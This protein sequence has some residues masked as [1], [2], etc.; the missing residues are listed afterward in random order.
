MLIIKIILIVTLGFIFYQD[1]KERQVYWFLFPLIAINCGVLHYFETLP[2]L[3]FNAVVINLIFVSAL[4]IVVFL[5]A[6]YKLKAPF[7]QTIGFG[8][9]LVF[10]ALSFSFSTVTFIILFNCGLLFSLALH[11]S[12]KK[13]LITVPLAG[14]MSLFFELTYLV[15]WSGF[16]NSVYII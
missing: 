2:E 8:D 14:Y 9:L 3:F 5:Y 13:N 12:I 4:L 1:V 15:Y 11:I 10:L 7:A 16:I 6:R